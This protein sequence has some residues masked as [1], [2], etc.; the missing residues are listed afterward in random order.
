MPFRATIADRSEG[1][2]RIKCAS[3]FQQ[4]FQLAVKWCTNV[5]RF[6]VRRRDDFALAAN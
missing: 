1:T 2:E 4:R 6:N 3:G 5:F